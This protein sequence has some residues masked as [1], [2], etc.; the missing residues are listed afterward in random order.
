[1]LNGPRG[2]DWMY[3]LYQRYSNDTAWGYEIAQDFFDDSLYVRRKHNNAWQGWRRVL[4]DGDSATIPTIYTTTVRFNGLPGYI[5]GRSDGGMDLNI[6][7]GW[8]FVFDGTNHAIY[9]YNPGT[10]AFRQITV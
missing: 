5:T 2:A 10:G 7:N 6:G 3:V 4:Y 8:R 1:M 9:T